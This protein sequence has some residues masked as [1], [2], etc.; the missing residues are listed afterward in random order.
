[1]QL[2][3]AAALA[4]RAGSF[5]AAFAF[6]LLLS[7]PATVYEQVCRYLKTF[8]ITKFVQKLHFH[9]IYCTMS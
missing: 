4:V 1:M 5:S 3:S 7:L 9:N 8:L 2:K 6:G